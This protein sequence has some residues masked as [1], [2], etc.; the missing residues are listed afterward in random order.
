M[1]NPTTEQL[2]KANL[3]A[4]GFTNTSAAAIYNKIAQAVGIIIDNTVAEINNSETIITN[5][6]ISQYGFG[7]PLYYTEN[8]LA[9]QYGDNLEI[10]MAIN[11]ATGAPYLNLIYPVIDT[12]KQIIKQAAFQTITSGNTTQLL[13][14]VATIDPISG[15]LI[16]LSTPQLNAFTNYFL[17]FQIPGLPISII[18]IAGNT[19]NFTSIATYFASYDLPTLQTNLLTALLAFQDSFVFNGVFYDGD[20]QDYIKSNV[21]GIRDFFISNTTLDGVPFSGSVDLSAGYFNYVTGII[22]QV[23]YNPIS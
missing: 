17:N 4:L 6:L 16:P 3:Q 2:I 11:P 21:P 7:K 20:L 19:L 9:F 14:K 15:L 10:N 8:A 12:T 13:L 22:N 5:L 23:T 1:A 18:N